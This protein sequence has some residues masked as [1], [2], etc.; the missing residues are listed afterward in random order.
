M[1]A[2]KISVQ[3]TTLYVSALQH[4][5][6]AVHCFGG[7]LRLIELLIL[8]LAVVPITFGPR[9]RHIWTNCVCG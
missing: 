1:F 8:L 5:S 4:A 6:K 7:A 9:C 3:A 2:V